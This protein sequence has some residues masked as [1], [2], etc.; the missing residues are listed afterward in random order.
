MVH[1]HGGSH[2]KKHF[3]R[4][5]RAG[6]RYADKQSQVNHDGRIQQLQR[7]VDRQIVSLR[8]AKEGAEEQTKKSGEA[9]S[10]VAHE[11]DAAMQTEVLNTKVVASLSGQLAVLHTRPL[12]PVRPAVYVPGRKRSETHVLHTTETPSR[13]LYFWPSSQYHRDPDSDL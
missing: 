10:Q 12:H 8:Q 4:T 9:L 5:N 3:G 13:E 7:Q 11:R 2:G 6:V 1:H